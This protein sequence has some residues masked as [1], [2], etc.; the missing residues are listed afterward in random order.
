MTRRLDQK[1]NDSRLDWGALAALAL[2]RLAISSGVS[3]LGYVA[4][5][6]DDYARVAIAQRFAAEPRLDPSGTSWLPFPFWWTGS[7]MRLL[8]PSL[9]VARI[10]AG[11][12]AIGATWLLFAAARWWGFSTGGAWIAALLANALPSA[13]LLGSFTTPEFPTAALSLFA[14]LA[15][16]AP[17]K[18]D[19]AE[20]RAK[21]VRSLAAAGALL[22]ATL[23]RYEAWP[24]AM[25][26]AGYAAAR[27][28]G[29]K[30]GWRAAVVLSSLAGPALWLV[31]NRILHG[32]ALS[33]LRRVA[34]YRAALGTSAPGPDSVLAGA[35]ILLGV[36]LFALLV[37]WRMP[38]LD[39]HE[40]ASLLVWTSAALALVLFLAVGALLGGAPTHHTERT[41]LFLWLLGLF[42][43]IHLARAAVRRTQIALAVCAAVLLVL[44]GVTQLS[45]RGID[46]RAEEAIGGRLH[47]LVSPGEHV[48]VAT[49]DYG[50]FAISAAFGRPLDIVVD[51]TH[52]PRESVAHSILDDESRILDILN[53][54]RAPW[55]VAPKD[56]LLPPALER[57]ST[58]GDLSI[59]AVSPTD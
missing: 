3:A 46:R 23:S 31:D 4:L 27:R 20:A 33:F 54:A 39:R 49:S 32:D 22:A 43:A 8:D 17:G 40:R 14:V 47:S 10:A 38:V 15:I 50:Y 30:G 18:G 1:R 58:A 21:L 16:T 53:E 52:D 29:P 26:V 5:S 45:D 28:D 36:A 11:A 2:A 9:D 44:D 56:A 41:L 51:Q 55:L 19:P 13:A 7:A 12:A 24:I 34:R 35:G 37:R 25:V 57:R 59:F 48:Y 42:A 6:D